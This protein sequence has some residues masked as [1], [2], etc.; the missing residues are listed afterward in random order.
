M[1]MNKQ[2]KFIASSQNSAT[3]PCKLL[4]KQHFLIKMMALFAFPLEVQRHD[5]EHAVS[6]PKS[7]SG[8][9]AAFECGR[10]QHNNI[11]LAALE[12]VAW[13]TLQQRYRLQLSLPARL[14]DVLGL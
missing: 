2:V 9:T 3:Q 1:P 10:A 5:G 13:P 12:T 7:V 6:H 11:V 4:F 14:I 8:L